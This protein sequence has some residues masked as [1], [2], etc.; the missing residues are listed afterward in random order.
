MLFR[1]S[2]IGGNITGGKNEPAAGDNNTPDSVGIR[3]GGLSSDTNE[4]YSGGT[5]GVSISNVPEAEPT[6]NEG[7]YGIGGSR[8]GERPGRDVRLRAILHIKN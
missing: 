3:P 7:K 5:Q 8:P 4:V 1:A 2:R 6:D